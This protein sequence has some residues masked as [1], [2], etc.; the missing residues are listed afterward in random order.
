MNINHRCV[1]KL[2]VNKIDLLERGEIAKPGDYADKW[3]WD[4]KKPRKVGKPLFTGLRFEIFAKW[5][6]DKFD[7]TTKQNRMK[8]LDVAGGSGKLSAQ[9]E[10]LE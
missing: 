1:K 2:N 4:R 3:A 8:I 6:V 10:K 7:D 5:C 9:L